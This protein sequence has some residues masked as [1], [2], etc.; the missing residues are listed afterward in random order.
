MYIEHIRKVGFELIEVRE[1]IGGR[2]FY[3][4]G[5][6]RTGT[7][8]GARDEARRV[9]AQAFGPEG[10]ERR[11]NVRALSEK[12]KACWAEGGPSRADFN[13][14]IEALH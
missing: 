3:R 2:P 6:R 11:R 14:L 7:E 9:L 1:W 5:V 4:G 12:M 13:S 8:Q 10:E